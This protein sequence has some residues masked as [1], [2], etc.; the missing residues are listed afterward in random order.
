MEI[1]WDQC[2]QAGWDYL[3]NL[4]RAPMQQRWDYGATHA[5]LGGQV[6]RAVITQN[7]A[8]VALCQS[9]LCFFYLYFLI[10]FQIMVALKENQD[11]KC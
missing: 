5:A 2:G 6:H 9:I 7:G 8:P 3:S 10:L 4:A 1:S 11:L